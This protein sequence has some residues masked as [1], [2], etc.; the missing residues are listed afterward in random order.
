MKKAVGRSEKDV[1]AGEIKVSGETTKKLEY[2]Q[3]HA[4]WAH[5]NACITVHTSRQ[6]DMFEKLTTAR[7]PIGWAR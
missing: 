6:M 5:D 4:N 2:G 7:P 3:S 1:Q